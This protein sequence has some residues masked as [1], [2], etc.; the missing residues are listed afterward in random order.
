MPP[1][2]SQPSYL[3]DLVERCRRGDFSA[4]DQVRPEDSAAF[5]QMLSRALEANRNRLA[6][7]ERT[8]ETL[9]NFFRF[10]VSLI[11]SSMKAGL[12]TWLLPP[13]ED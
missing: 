2:P 12:K 13:K 4:V 7:F 6:L 9:R 8:E 3:D 5:S 10:L 11:T 1:E